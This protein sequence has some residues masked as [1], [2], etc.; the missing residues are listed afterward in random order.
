MTGPTGP[1]VWNSSVGGINYI[2]GNVG[3]GTINPV[4]KLDVS[5]IIHVGGL[6]VG[7]AT[8]ATDGQ[9]YASGKIT[10]L[11][12][13]ASSDYRMKT[14]IQPISVSKI[15]DLL[16][17]VEY[18]LLHGIHDMGFIAHE[19]QEQFSFLVSGE[20]DGDNMQTLNYNGFI[21]LLVKEMQELKKRLNDA[22][23]NIKFLL[24]K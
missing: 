9:I 7:T 14:N 21:A 17:P 16:K 13:N 12:L 5:G 8:A 1:N 22:E 20:K 6:N 2:S 3:I 19:V 18:D 15:V 10:G 11:S 24:N 4:Y 23:E